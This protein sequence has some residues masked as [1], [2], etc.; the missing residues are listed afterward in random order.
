[1]QRPVRVS[2]TVGVRVRIDG[3]DSISRTISSRDDDDER[4][5]FLTYRRVCMTRIVSFKRFRAHGK[6]K[7][8]D[9]SFCRSVFSIPKPIVSSDGLIR[10][11]F[12]KLASR[13][14]SLLSPVR[15]RT[16]IERRD[17]SRSCERR[18]SSSAGHRSSR[19]RD[20]IVTAFTTTAT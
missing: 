13:D 14:R 18:Q 3:I 9:E 16:V 8:I 1:M 20:I 6:K 19:S 15:R 2:R 11:T 12:L 5:S 4:A 10:R 7:K 17:E